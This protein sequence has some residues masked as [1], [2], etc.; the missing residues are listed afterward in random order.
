MGA[1]V[2]S[3]SRQTAKLF[4]ALAA[5][6][7]GSS[8]CSACDRTTRS[9]P[10]ASAR[11]LPQAPAASAVDSTNVLTTDPQKPPPGFVQVRV[12][13]VTPAAQGNAVLLI[14][15]TSNRAL[16]VFIGDTEALSIQLRLEGTRYKRP[17][18]H[19][20]IDNMLEH[21]G[22][23]IQSVRVDRLDDD[24]FYGVVVLRDGQRIH[25]FDSRTSD[26]IALAVGSKAPVFVAQDVLDRAGIAV[27]SE[28]LPDVTQGDVAPQRLPI[29]L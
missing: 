11:E 9:A 20:L 19:D 6:V 28:G 3:G 26:G 27:D 29:A 21:L 25:E 16:V 17:L 2:V 10:S 18:T 12:G 1:L 4:V 15:D 22:A 8:L 14:D 7:A 13:G 23:K 24:I 5:L